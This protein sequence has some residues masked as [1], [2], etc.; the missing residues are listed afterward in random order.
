MPRYNFLNLRSAMYENASKHGKQWALGRGIFPDNDS[1]VNYNRTKAG[2]EKKQS[3]S[4]DKRFSAARRTLRKWTET[5]KF[6]GEALYR[7]RKTNYGCAAGSEPHVSTRVQLLSLYAIQ[8][9]LRSTALSPESPDITLH[10][11]SP[12]KEHFSKNLALCGTGAVLSG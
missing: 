10:D 5:I 1:S 4:R 9:D 3:S 12:S 2:M 11:I 6:E 8:A 7:E